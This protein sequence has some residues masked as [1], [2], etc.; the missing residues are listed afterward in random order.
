MNKWQTLQLLASVAGATIKRRAAEPSTW[1]GVAAV[2]G[3]AAQ[4]AATKDP[5]AIGAAVAGVVAILAPE[6][7]Q[8][9]P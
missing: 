3:S 6:R 9:K 7:G 1:A 2:I 4:A 8:A 5:A